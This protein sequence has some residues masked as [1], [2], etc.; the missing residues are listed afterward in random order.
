MWFR[1]SGGDGFYAVPDPNDHHLVYAE[2]QQAGVQRYDERTGEA[3]SIRPSAPNGQHL[4]WNWSTPILPSTHTRNTVYMAAQYLFK[5]TDRGDSWTMISPDLTRDIDRNTLPMRGA[6]PDSGELGRNEGTAEFSNITTVDESPLKAGVLAVGTDDGLIQVS[7]NDGKSWSKTEHFPG[8]PDTTYVSRVAWSAASPGRL[9]ASFD[10]HRSNDFKPYVLVSEDYGKSWKSISGNLPAMSGVEVVREDPR[11]PNL[12]FA[13]TEFGAFFSTDRG[14]HWSQL[15]GNFPAVPVWDMKI[16]A[17]EN[18]LV[19]ATHGRGIWIMD[20]ITPLEQLAEARAAKTAYLFPVRDELLFQPDNTHNSGMTSYG[21]EG[22]NPAY[23][24][25]IT[26][27]L[28]GQPAAPTVKLDVLDA[29]GAVVRTLPLTSD[30]KTGG[31]HRVEWDMKAGPPLTGPV[32]TDSAIDARAEEAARGGRGGFGGGG[33][34]GRGR[35]NGEVTYPVV[36]GRYTARLTVTPAGGGA[37]TIINRSFTLTRDAAQVMAQNDLESLDHFRR[38]FATF[39]V[40]HRAA[41]EQVDSMAAAYE[42]LKSAADRAGDKLTPA[43]KTQLAQLDSAVTDVYCDIG[44]AGG[45]RGGR[46]GGGGGGGRGGRGGAGGIRCPGQFGFGG[47]GPED[48]TPDQPV[49]LTITQKVQ[50]MSYLTNVTF[51]P[52]AEQ[53]KNLA[54]LPGD[55]KAAEAKMA[56]VRT[57]DIPAFEAAL[58]AAGVDLTPP[59]RGRRG[60]RGGRGGN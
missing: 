9:Y 56:R 16:Q 7:M 18:D 58:K 48:N 46:G 54:A 28:D 20:D 38:E 60:G 40:S 32:P 27:L 39:E 37:T 8:V 24:A 11:Q 44:S 14:G 45:G 30:D 33:F 25:I 41:Q 6:V 1:M 3:K 22:E 10:G 42:P 19:L 13:G 26:Y 17:R 29:S 34:F 23:G 35:G 43:L 49:K 21:F 51:E 52:T 5:S 53:R 36:P 12:L 55:L 31:M 15:T 57:K 4:R 47:G 59:A 2:S 50:G